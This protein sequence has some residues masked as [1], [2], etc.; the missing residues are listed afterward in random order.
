MGPAASIEING[1]EKREKSR[2]AMRRADAS[3]KTAGA[4]CRAKALVI[5]DA[6][7]AEATRFRNQANSRCFVE[8]WR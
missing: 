5:Q 1:R 2:G 3:C 8:C 4:E 7:R 6:P